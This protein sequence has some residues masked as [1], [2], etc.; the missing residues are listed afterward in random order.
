[1]VDLNSVGAKDTGLITWFISLISTL[2]T[3][4]EGFLLLAEL[5]GCDQRS[6]SSYVNRTASLLYKTQVNLPRGSGDPSFEICAPKK[7]SDEHNLTRYEFIN[8]HET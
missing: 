8:L 3:V 7:I 2:M 1:M 5:T 6:A 4:P